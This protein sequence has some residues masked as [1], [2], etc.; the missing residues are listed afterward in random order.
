MKTTKKQQTI[1]CALA[2]SALLSQSTSITYAAEQE[3]FGFDQVVV[4][5][6]RVPQTVASTPADVTVITAK[7]IEDKGARNLADAL[8]SI[9]GVVVAKNGGPGEIAVPYILGTDRVVVLIDGK[10]MNIPQGIGSGNGGVNLNTIM[11]ADNIERIEIVRGGGSVLYGADAVGGV[12]NII[13]KG[14]TG[15]TKTTVDFGGGSNATSHLAISNQGAE[16]GWHWYITGMQDNTDGQLRNSDYK[17]KNTTVRIDRDL[18]EN[19]VLSINYD[20]YD[21]HA[22]FPGS[23]KYPTMAD[24]GD[25]LRHNF[26]TTYTNKNKMG[27]STLK[28]YS[29]DQINSGYAWGDSF[30]HK[31][32]VQGIEYQENINVREKH[33]FTWGGEW[34]N[35]KTTS[36][37]EVSGQ[38]KRNVKAAYIQ[39]RYDMN[40][41]LTITTGLRYDDNSQYGDNWL[42]KVA[43]NYKTDN[44][45]SY[46]AS[47]GKVARAPKFDDLYGDDG[48]GN[49]GN[50]SLKAETGWTAEIGAKKQVS[51]SSEG[52]ITLFKH[53]LSDAI[54]WQ[55]EDPNDSWSPMHPQNL[56]HLTTQ[57][58]TASFATKISPVL[59]GDVGYTYLDSRDEA[60]KQQAPHNTFNIGIKLQQ[61]KFMQNVYGRYVEKNNHVASYSVWDTTLN[62]AMNKD[63]SL[64]FNITNLFNKKYQI[65]NDYLAQERS[66]F[67]GVKQSF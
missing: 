5:A 29:Y 9:P 34:R 23:I 50:P 15:A 45:T 14:G 41:Y 49:T 55:N 42:P 65:V 44:K 20:Y 19:E 33:L 24:Y 4:T 2:V 58:I 8:E 7:E 59:S 52:T 26:G 67:V 39:D 62:Y 57:G 11:V 28:Y 22:G 13:T 36:T 47:W 38:H 51:A 53:S 27:D 32:D 6:N 16:N 60:N 61:G 46:F 12:I 66:I 1:L 37:S 25:V 21:S 17:G 18:S 40:Q 43:F 56:Q 10:R 35:E 48:Y 31:N 63:Q 30:R 54:K 3:E 64:Y